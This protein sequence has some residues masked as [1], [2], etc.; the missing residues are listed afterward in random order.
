M[1]SSNG[2][3]LIENGDFEKGFHG[4]STEPMEQP[5]KK[6]RQ[7]SYDDINRTTINMAL[8]IVSSGFKPRLIIPIVRGGV[9]PAA[10]LYAGLSRLP[11][12]N[13]SGWEI[14][15]IFAKSYSGQDQSPRMSLD[16]PAHVRAQINKGGDILIVDDIY[17]TGTTISMV[18]YNLRDSRRKADIR[19]AT[20]L[21]KDENG[22]DYFGEYLINKEEWIH[23][24]W[25]Q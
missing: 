10:F 20:L 14:M 25:E 3:N 16:I 18:N 5:T 9:I 24:P 6:I 12:I 13:M 19:I 4:W 17:D 11:N 8:Q 22:P 7:L 1:P 23:F 15:T 21:T 2:G